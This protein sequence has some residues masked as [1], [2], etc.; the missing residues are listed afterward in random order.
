MPWVKFIKAHLGARLGM[1]FFM[2]EVVTWPAKS[3][4]RNAF[5]E[6]F[7]PSIKTESALEALVLRPSYAASVAAVVEDPRCL[8]G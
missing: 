1:D 4:N 8:S 2:V 3:P 7:V 6:R 5:A